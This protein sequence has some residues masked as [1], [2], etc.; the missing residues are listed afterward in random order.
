MMD[1]DFNTFWNRYGKKRERGD[2]ERAWHRLSADEQQAAVS[3]ITAYRRRCE[4]QG[5]APSY[6][7]AY[8]NQ[9]LWQ[10]PRRGRTRQAKAEDSRTDGTGSFYGMEIW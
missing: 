5:T 9:R 2:A 4:Q 7:A 8:L 6:P 1:N 10:K 3:G